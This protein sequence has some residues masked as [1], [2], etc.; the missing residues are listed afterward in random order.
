MMSR[1]EWPSDFFWFV[2]LPATVAVVMRG[3]ETTRRAKTSR[4]QMQQDS[5]LFDHLVG[6]LLEKQRYFDAEC[7]GGLE[8]QQHHIFDG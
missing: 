2:W 8:I 4:E 5:P 7:L 1:E 6:A 3:S